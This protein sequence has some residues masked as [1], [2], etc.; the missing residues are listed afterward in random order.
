MIL[1]CAQRSVLLAQ[2]LKSE[3]CLAQIV[4]STTRYLVLHE[5][6]VSPLGATGVTSTI[7]RRHH[8]YR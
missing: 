7:H 5:L 3:I 2:Q 8:L 1:L 6:P 4:Q